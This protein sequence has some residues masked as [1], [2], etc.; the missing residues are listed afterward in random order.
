MCVK[1]LGGGGGGVGTC[2]Q[3]ENITRIQVGIHYG[4]PEEGKQVGTCDIII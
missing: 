1:G 4:C 3:V 2:V